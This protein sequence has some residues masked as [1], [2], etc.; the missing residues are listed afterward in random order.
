LTESRGPFADVDLLLVTHS[1]ADHF[2]AKLV[3]AHLR[4]DTRCRLIAS[5]ET[6]DHLR[7]EEGFAQI[8]DRIRKVTLAA[9]TREHVSVNGM[10]VDVL[11]LGGND[12]SDPS[13]PTSR[14]T[15]VINLNGV[16]FFHLGDDLIEQNEARLAA[17][18]FD[19]T[20]VDILF[21]RRDDLSAVAQQFIAR[22][23]KPSRTIAMHVPPAE[24]AA[25]LKNIHKA[26][27]CA[28][29][30]R[31]SM[32]RRSLPIEVDFHNLV[33]DYFGQTPPGATPQLFARGIVSTDD[34]EHCAP[35]FSPDGS[36][37]F[38]YSTRPPGPDSQE[39]F[40][41]HMTMRRENGRWSAPYVAPNGYR[42]FSADGRRAYLA[43]PGDIRVLEK[44]GNGWSEPRE[45]GLASRF[46]EL[47]TMFLPS[48]TRTGTLYFTSYAGGPSTNQR[49]YRIECVDGEYT[50]SELLPPA[51][52]CRRL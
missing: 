18:P 48:V 17:F 26:Y 37:V 20:P 4:N 2:N 1:H 31:Q 19:R 11:C 50:K 44:Q 30:F 10:E 24:L 47:K 41:F 51:S 9:G 16:R 33:G 5:A 15:F 39:A 40:F 35:A 34:N 12:G 43:Q 45:L 38:W 8:Q 23:I 3:T 13:D 27:P 21:L 42:V 25:E 28:I 14:L 29:V 52:T 7:N 22:K 32:E 46:P 6:V 49:I 36:E